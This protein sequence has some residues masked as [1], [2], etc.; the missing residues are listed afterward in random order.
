MKKI[1]ALIIVMLLLMGTIPVN[2]VWGADIKEKTESSNA[3][4]PVP[5]EQAKP[6]LGKDSLEKVISLVKSRL[7]IPAAYTDFSSD[8]YNN[9]GVSMFRLHWSTSSAYY[10]PVTGS[11][12]VTVDENGV[13]NNYYSYNYDRN[14][15]NNRRLPSISMVQAE[16]RAQ[17]FLTSM[18]PDVTSQVSFEKASERCNI[19]YD[20]SYSFYFYRL[21]DGIPY[22]DNSIYIQVNGQTGLVSSMNRN[23]NDSLVLPKADKVLSMAEAKEAYKKEI[24]LKLRYRL[25]SG[26]NGLKSTLQ[27]SPAASDMM[28][29]IDAVNGGKLT[30]N[31]MI[32]NPYNDYGYRPDM[33]YMGP[34]SDN[35]LNEIRQLKSLLDVKEG[36]KLARGIK[37]LG[38]SNT[39]HLNRYS[40]NRASGDGYTLQMEFMED[41]P[42]GD[43]Q[44]DIP[45]DKLKVMMA[46]GVIGGGGYANIVFDAET[47]ELISFNINSNNVGAGGSKAIAR[48]ELQKTADAFLGKYKSERFKQTELAP[49]AP[50][51]NDY[52]MKYGMATSDSN[53]NFIY[54]RTV[55]GITVDGNSLNI[56][57]DMSTGRIMS[58]SEVWDDAAFL[59]AD[60][61]ISLDKAYEILFAQNGFE[62][63]YITA[64]GP[65]TDRY[66]ISVTT[67]KP[68]PPEVK[69]VY[70]PG[71]NKPVVIDAAKGVLVN[72]ATGEE[73]FD[74]NMISFDDLAGNPNKADIESLA[75]SGL[76]PMQK[77][78]LP[79][80]SMLQKDFLRILFMLR[81]NSVPGMSTGDLTQTAQDGMYRQM[82]NDGMLTD[83]ERAPDAILTREQAVKFMLKSFGYGKFAEMKGIF[84]CSYTDKADIEPSLLG[85][86]A[87]AGSLGI[88]EGKAFEPK[89]ELTRLEAVMMIY[90]YVKR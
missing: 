38:I 40:Y 21:A 72:G 36:E 25:I 59:P 56:N 74:K 41:A 48:T 47:S 50:Y 33:Y 27:Y 62:L 15:D 54:N 6:L 58:Y 42:K 34:L 73:Y 78:F 29:A 31:N 89:K 28:F 5:Q 26:Q 83:E 80:D 53:G 4:K 9:G 66:G 79:G 45:P 22:Y 30:V 18:C 82:I 85:Y 55:N 24:G 61:I 43:L 1:T 75:K 65:N 39:Y 17:R 49:S 57:L 12:E 88:I 10:S 35:D 60:R 3:V 76:L 32:Y 71:N 87:I 13:V 7:E 51:V 2:P 14:Y 69:L 84:D 16:E 77:S 70:S 68:V 23:W 90:R 81:G 20:G 67:G 64:V 37:E 11:M 52:M 63:K 44:K 86:A 46:A 19:E 8:V